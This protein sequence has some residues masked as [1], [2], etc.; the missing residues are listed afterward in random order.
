MKIK[1]FFAVLAAVVSASAVQGAGNQLKPLNGKTYLTAHSGCERT[2]QNTIESIE[3]GIRCGADYIEFDLSFTADGT[4]VLSHDRPKPG[5]K[6][7]SLENAFKTLKKY[8]GIL[9]NVDV[10]STVNLAAVKRMA[11]EAGI[12]D[13]IFYSGIRAEDV[14]E[15]KRQSPGVPFFLNVNIGRRTNIDA[16]I[17]HAKKIGARGLNLQYK[18]ASANLVKKCHKAGLEVSVWTVDNEKDIKR[19]FALGV[20]N[21]ASNKVVLSRKIIGSGAPR[22][23]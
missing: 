14:E 12:I 10:K 23:S 8:K 17:A 9:F 1:T 22:R 6:Y 4:P 15:M 11:V 7:E 16:L 21:I 2:K 18:G 20:D 3:K 5:V 13:R 19:M